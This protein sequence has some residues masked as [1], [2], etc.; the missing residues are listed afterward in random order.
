M[1]LQLTRESMSAL[2]LI[3]SYHHRFG[4]NKNLAEHAT[5]S[6]TKKKRKK[7]RTRRKKLRKCINNKCASPGLSI[8]CPLEAKS[9]NWERGDIIMHNS[10]R[11]RVIEITRAGSHHLWLQHLNHP[12][13]CG[14]VIRRRW[15]TLDGHWEERIKAFYLRSFAHRIDD[16]SWTVLYYQE[17]QLKIA[18]HEY[19]IFVKLFR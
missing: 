3:D 10:I 11:I 6:P 1:F 5:W 16:F 12:V 8:S 17:I 18:I 13:H 9:R 19:A 7:K 14:P 4:K 15:H 2:R